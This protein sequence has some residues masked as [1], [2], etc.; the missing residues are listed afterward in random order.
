MAKKTKKKSKRTST[1][2]TITDGDFST[3][4]NGLSGNRVFILMA[5]TINLGNY[6]S[7]RV[8]FGVGRT[9]SD[10][11]RFDSILS[12]CRDDVAQNLKE[13]VQLVESKY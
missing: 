3:A 13:M 11:E 1:R 6:E 5:K 12:V 8:E 4:T 7:V 2:P 9:V 10:G